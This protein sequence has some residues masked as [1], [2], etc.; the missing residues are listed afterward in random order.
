M[1]FVPQHILMVS[2]SYS[3]E[4]LAMNTSPKI[5][6]LDQLCFDNRFVRDLPADVEP[7]NTRRQVLGACYSRVLPTAV[8]N[9]RC[10]AYAFEVADLLDL[11]PEL[12][13]SDD[14]TQ[15]FAGNRLSKGMDAYAT[16]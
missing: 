3:V 5:T 1:R 8:T 11:S 6:H 10:I 13:A 12:C 15:V 16:C 9:P 7:L 4:M 2:T 14:F